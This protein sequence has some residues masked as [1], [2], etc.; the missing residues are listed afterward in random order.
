MTARLAGLSLAGLSLAGLSLAGLSL[1]G[2]LALGGCSLRAQ[3]EGVVEPAAAAAPGEASL[4]SLEGRRWR[5]VLDEHSAPL[6]YL[7]GC[8]VRAEGRRAGSRIAVSGWDVVA[9]ADG[10]EPFVGWIRS[11]GDGLVI[12]DH[13]TGSALALEPGS[14]G[15]LGAFVDEPVM[16]VGFA[17]GPHLIRVMAYTVLSEG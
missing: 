15:D 8:T 14:V 11:R 7:E 13:A 2:G 10:S 1:A 6:A 5:L 9:A 4:R 16:I 3:V 17:V 12:E